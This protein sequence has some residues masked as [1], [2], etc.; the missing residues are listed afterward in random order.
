[1][2]AKKPTDDTIKP[3]SDGAEETAATELSDEELSEVTGAGLSAGTFLTWDGTGGNN[4]HTI[5]T[6]N[7]AGR[8]FNTA[9]DIANFSDKLKR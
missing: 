1:M 9:T 6:F 8:D 2:S 7:T 5:S 3:E 4:F